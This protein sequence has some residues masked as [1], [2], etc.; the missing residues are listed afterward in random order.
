MT[1]KYL[2]FAIEV[3]SDWDDKGDEWSSELDVLWDV[4][5]GDDVDAAE[6]AANWSYR[7]FLTRPTAN[8]D[9]LQGAGIFVGIQ[10][11]IQ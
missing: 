11:V 10:M 7:I 9:A 3:S 8:L 6:D 2:L 1:F 4:I 5:E